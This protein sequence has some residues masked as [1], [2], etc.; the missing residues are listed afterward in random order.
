MDAL[1]I[2]RRFIRRALHQLTEQS[3]VL[4]KIPLQ[5]GGDLETLGHDIVKKHLLLLSNAKGGAQQ[6][7]I[8]RSDGHWF[9]CQH[10]ETVFD[11]LIDVLRF[12]Q[13]VAGNYNHIPGAVLYHLLRKSGPVWTF[14][15]HLVGFSAR[16]L[17][18]SIRLR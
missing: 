12:T 15:S 18:P 7:K 1:F 8:V 13:V 14:V 3:F 11:G 16:V 17:K 9:V 5:N 10:V 6:F 2:D 4:G